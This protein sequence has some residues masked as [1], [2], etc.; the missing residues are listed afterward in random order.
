MTDLDSTASSAPKSRSHFS[1]VI[2]LVGTGLLC[3]YVVMPMASRYVMTGEATAGGYAI[4]A[5]A[6]P[7]VTPATQALIA[8]RFSKGYLTRQDVSDL[9]DPLVDE[10]GSVQVSPAPDFGDG[11]ATQE[12]EY[13]GLQSYWKRYK[14]ERA[15][16][17]SKAALAQ[18]IAGRQPG[19]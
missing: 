7:S 11:D 14:G 1:F 18:L 19:V 9:I 13:I 4:L 8:A 16:Y 17:K 6:Y 12:F 10:K 3:W 5:E 15:S 2:W